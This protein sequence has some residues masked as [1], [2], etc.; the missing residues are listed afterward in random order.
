VNKALGLFI[1]GCLVVTPLLDASAAKMNRAGTQECDGAT[2]G[3]KDAVQDGKKVNC[4]FDTCTYTVQCNETI[5]GKLVVKKCTHVEYDGATAR[6]CKPVASTPSSGLPGGVLIPTR[7]GGSQLAPT[8]DRPR[9]PTKVWKFQKAPVTNA[10]TTDKPKKTR[11]SSTGTMKPHCKG[12]RLIMLKSMP[13]QWRCLCPQG[14]RK[15]RGKC[16]KNKPKT[17][18]TINKNRIQ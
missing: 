1:F 13:P 9:F 17:G 6:D 18:P 5:D 7:P 14:W 11:P 3:R 4:L 15:V 16:T 10:P 2:T 8:K 12:G